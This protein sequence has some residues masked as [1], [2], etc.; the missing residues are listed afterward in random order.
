MLVTEAA[1]GMT[2]VR[3]GATVTVA[4]GVGC[5]VAAPWGF[6]DGDAGPDATSVVGRAGAGC[7]G[8]GGSAG[9]SRPSCLANHVSIMYLAMGAAEY[10]KV[11]RE[12]NLAAALERMKETGIWVFGAASAGGAPPWSVDFTGPTCLV[13][14]SEG[15]GLRSLVSRTC[16]RLVT[17]PMGGRIGSLNVAAAAAVLCYEVARQRGRGHHPDGKTP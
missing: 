5:A 12:A 9:S 14:G 3:H 13:L 6:G 16:D 2:S 15:G 11:A 17:V 7:P 10:V 1:D 8:R 4:E